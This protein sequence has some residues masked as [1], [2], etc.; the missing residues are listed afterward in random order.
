[1]SF[2]DL[3]LVQ[4]IFNIL[5]VIYGVIPGQDFGIA[6][7]IFTVIVRLLMWPLVK[8]QLHQTKIMR[9]MQPELAKIKKRA[10]GN[11]QL[12]SQMMLELYKEKGVSPFSSIGTLLLQLPIFIALFAVVKLITENHDNIAKFTY[13]AFEGIP[14]I[15]DAIAGQINHHLFGVIDLTKHATDPGGGMYWPLIVMA[16]IAA[17]LQYFQSKML[18]PQPKEKRKLRDML[19]EQAAGK[20]VDQAEMSAQMTGKMVWLFPILTFMVA[21]YLEGALVLYLLTTNIVAIVQQ[22]MVLEKDE[23]DL[24]KIS[25]KTKTRVEKAVEA[26]VVESK[27]K[28]GST[29]K[30]RR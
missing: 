26:E 3:I 28:K 10:K 17:I 27:T 18:L 1:M 9:Q 29:K 16:V 14:G 20:E 24:K 12:E 7:I 19:K 6:L 22:K 13:D 23:T 5:V 8:K 25:E 15:R 11:R 2:F 4:P 21:I 30:K